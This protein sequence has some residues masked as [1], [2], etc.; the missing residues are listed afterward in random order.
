[1]IEETLGYL[2]DV[3]YKWA[4]RVKVKAKVVVEWGWDEGG[5]VQGQTEVL[6][7][8]S[9]CF[10]SYNIDVRFIIIQF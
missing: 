6:C 7:E 5:V 1:M 10:V 2:V 8:F 9:G 4:V 3:L